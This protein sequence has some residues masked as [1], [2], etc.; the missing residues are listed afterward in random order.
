MIVWSVYT[1]SIK[2][3]EL[4]EISNLRYEL[5]VETT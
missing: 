5:Y 1:S 2:Q 4:A 3:H